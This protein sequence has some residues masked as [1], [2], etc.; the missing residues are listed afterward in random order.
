MMTRSIVFLCL[1]VNNNESNLITH[2]DRTILLAPCLQ[3]VKFIIIENQRTK[4]EDIFFPSIFNEI[5]DII[6]A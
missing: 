2:Y 3:D 5:L 4:V 6:S 1:H